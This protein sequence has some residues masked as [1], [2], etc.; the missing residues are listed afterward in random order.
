M[1]RLSDQ[2][3]DW[4]SRV[5]LLARG[6]ERHRADAVR[7]LEA[8][9]AW[10]ARESALSI[11]DELPRSR[12]GLLLWAD[13]AEAALLD[14]EVVEALERLG[15]ELPFR[16][17]VWY[18]LAQARNR[19]G[20]PPDEDGFRAA[21]LPEPTAA[22]DAARL[23]LAD[24]DSA[25]GDSARAER[26]LS[27]LSLAGRRSEA[28]GWRRLEMAL[29]A[30]DEAAA[31]ELGS[32]LPVPPALDARAWLV[33]ARWLALIGDAQAPAAWVRAVLLGAPGLMP[34]LADHVARQTS[35][36]HRSFLLGLAKDAGL[37]GDPVLRAAFARAEG[38]IDLAL[39]A[40]AEAAQGGA[41]GS[42]ERYLS[43]ALDARSAERVQ[44]AASLVS[45]LEPA[46]AALVEA[47]R[48][49]SD[50]ARLA[51]LDLADGDWADALRWEVFARWLPVDA[52]PRFAELLVELRRLGRGLADFE[53]WP[54]IAQVERD[55]ERP[56]RVAIVGEFNAGKSSLINALIG[57]DVAP[58]GV[59]PTTATLNQLIWAPDRFARIER[60]DGGP[61]RVVPHAE[62]RRALGE[63]PPEQVR[64]VGIYAPLELLRKLELTDTPG[65]NA[66]DSAHAA[67]ARVAFRDAH[68]ALW[69]LDATQPL[70][71]SERV[72][73]EE[74][75]EQG[76]PLVVLV[77]KLDRLPDDAALAAAL[78]HVERGLAQAGVTTESPVLALS[79][80][81][82]LAGKAGDAAALERSRFA[83]VEAL[84]D[85]VVVGRSEALKARVLLRRCLE[86]AQRLSARADDLDRAHA[87]ERDRLRALRARL[88]EAGALLGERDRVVRTLEPE[89]EAAVAAFLAD[90]RRVATI[91][92]DPGAR[93]FVRQRARAVLAP[94]LVRALLSVLGV[95][96]GDGPEL[97]RA[98]APRVEALAAVSAVSLLATPGEHRDLV[99][100][101]VEEAAAA[102]A[103]LGSELGPGPPA[104][105]V[106]RTRTL[107][108]V[109]LESTPASGRPTC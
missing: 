9:R 87:A 8:G 100:A 67:T 90:T 93:R 59:L 95:R 50:D 5:E 6:A 53:T 104:P 103:A 89:C 70:K 34:A 16:A 75:R 32:A 61:D 52:P 83:E 3:V 84:V 107:C 78:D 45:T 64:R 46:V 71:D 51:A 26:W 28:A 10:D 47:L 15:R 82:A 91:V 13:A 74:I 55:L 25:R 4:L 23:W 72:V 85:R 44:H 62:L 39:A 88:T 109:L 48:A 105:F 81:L 76:L 86:I 68:V 27:Q 7:A 19:L 102:L 49:K 11:V 24:R 31:R 36:E 17:D 35:A 42:P 30:R 73:L 2:L 92:E 20:Q 60:G 58:V 41:P 54:D 33:R 12:V 63:V 101:L 97:R 79:A 66:P 21:E 65:F 96:D 18:R 98:L 106:A 1:A 80:R 94:P 14:H 99:L 38:S 29:D 77:N 69:L 108:R 43:L 56:L 57:E 22:A 37:A 40:L